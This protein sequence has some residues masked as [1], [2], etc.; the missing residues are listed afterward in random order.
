MHAVGH[1]YPPKIANE[2]RNA[3]KL[4]DLIT[5]SF[6]PIVLSFGVLKLLGSYY[7]VFS[8]MSQGR[9]ELTCF[10]TGLLLVHCY[11]VLSK[12]FFGLSPLFF[13]VEVQL[14]LV[15]FPLGR[16]SGTVTV[17]KRCCCLVVVN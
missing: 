7:C 5:I 17:N 1:R 8:L 14:E 4:K 6:V 2:G 10:C 16:T 9:Q 13:S 3:L 15:R 12:T 11:G